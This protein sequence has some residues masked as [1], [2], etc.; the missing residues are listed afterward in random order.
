V[1]VIPFLLFFFTF[2]LNAKIKEIKIID[3]TEKKFDFS[4]ACD[5]KGIT[6]API[7][8][9]KNSITLS[10][11]G[12]M[13]KIHEFCQEKSEG[14]LIKSYIDKDDEKVVCQNGTGAKLKISCDKIHQSYC[15]SKI[16][17]CKRVH[18]I[19]AK[20]T[21]LVHSSITSEDGLKT[22]NCYFLNGEGPDYF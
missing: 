15:E 16:K 9:V 6:P 12:V 19:I 17:G 5:F 18:K 22:L 13:V 3:L 4:S 2:G 10:C 21:P 7:I 11:M 14:N 8:E 1:R 20:N